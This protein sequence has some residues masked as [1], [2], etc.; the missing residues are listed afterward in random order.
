MRGCTEPE[1]ELRGENRDEQVF[2]MYVRLSDGMVVTTYVDE[3]GRR[4]Y[5]DPDT[6]V[7]RIRA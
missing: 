7:S 1:Q 3:S 5:M 4:L 6:L 2:E